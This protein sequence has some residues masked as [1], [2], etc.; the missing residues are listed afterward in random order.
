MMSLMF[1]CQ[2]HTDTPMALL[3]S[4]GFRMILPGRRA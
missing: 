4:K 3:P 2:L 1:A